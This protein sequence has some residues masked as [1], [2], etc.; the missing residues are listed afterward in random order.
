VE[1]DQSNSGQY[2][3]LNNF[4]STNCCLRPQ[5]SNGNEY[6]SAINSSIAIEIFSPTCD[7]PFFPGYIATL[8]DSLTSNTLTLNLSSH[9]VVTDIC[10]EGN[11][12]GLFIS[13]TAPTT[14][15]TV[16][17]SVHSSSHSNSLVLI[18]GIVFGVIGFLILIAIAAVVV[19]IVFKK[20]KEMKINETF[21][22][23]L[24]VEK[25]ESSKSEFTPKSTI[26]KS[27]YRI[28]TVDFPQE[29]TIPYSSLQLKE[30]IGHGNFGEV[31]RAYY[32]GTGTEVA[33]KQL[34]NQKMNKKESGEFVRE[35][36][37]MMQ[38]GEHK[39]VLCLYGICLEPLCLVT[40]FCGGG[41]LDKLLFK[42][43]TDINTHQIISFCRD[44]T[45]GLA[46]LH[47]CGLIHRDL[48]ARNVL[49]DADWNSRISDFGMSRIQETD[50]NVTKSDFGPLKW[51]APEAIVSKI[52]S[53]QTDIYSL[54]VV[55]SE[56]L[57]R[58]EP[59]PNMQAVVV[60]IE[61]VQN[62][63]RPNLPDYIPDALDDLI[64]KMFDTDP[65]KRP[66]CQNIIKVLN[67]VDKTWE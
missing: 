1:F 44:I 29:W 59:Y 46:H 54:A 58:H 32:D 55:F 9:I 22:T 31:Y 13:C 20:R 19:F 43:K 35:G 21:A 7:D 12:P 65:D 61:V 33:V 66:S 10:N 45:S 49:L 3:I 51:M 27:N 2:P 62:G 8:H 34:L 67:E 37:L 23:E 53:V 41:S 24:K 25:Y 15:T 26:S 4:T 57:N 18:L 56:I 40:P 39:N 6:M 63:S 52:Y 50:K 11:N 64:W 38:L 47:I 48:A 30:K 14:K 60:A 16:H 17:S 36:K 5:D 42:T 28:S